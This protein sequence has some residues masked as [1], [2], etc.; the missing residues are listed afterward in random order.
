MEKKDEIWKDIEDF[1]GIYQISSFGRVKSFKKCK[2][3]ILK[4]GVAGGGYLFVHLCKDGK[5]KEMKI[6]RLVAKAFI[7][8]P[9][10]LPCVNHL[11]ENK[12]NNFVSN[13]EWCDV[14]YNVNYG[15][16]NKRTSDKLTNGPLS[17]QVGQ[18]SLDGKLIRIWPSMIEAHRN[19]FNVGHICSCC[20]GKRKS[21]GGFIWQYI[22]N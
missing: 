22:E 12:Q 8:N 13:L 11:D 7:P 6:H 9:D 21:H 17:K 15:T 14:K 19:G 16:R 3:R 4:P 1:E 2:E 18:Y 10:K 20:K 5:I